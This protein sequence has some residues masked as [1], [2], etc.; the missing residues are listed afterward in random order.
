MAC[1]IEQDDA[2][3]DDEPDEQDEAH[4]A[5]HVQRRA[6]DEQ[7]HHGTNKREWCG[8]EDHE[9]FDERLELEH[10][11]RDDARRR[12]AEDEQEGTKCV[13]LA[14]V[15]AADLDADTARRR[16]LVEDGAHVGHHGAQG[17]RAKIGMHR[18]HLLLI[19]T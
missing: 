15:L 1:E 7:E 16:V 4:E 9:R 12:Q 6:G 14:G 10:H 3:L 13:L 5:R 11:D 17:S 8:E 18:D 2:V 19:L